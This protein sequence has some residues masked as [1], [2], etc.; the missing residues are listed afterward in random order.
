MTFH[1][2]L[3]PSNNL[4]QV[5]TESGRYYQTEDGTKLWSV[6]TL[7]DKVLGDPKKKRSLENW[8]KSVGKEKADKILIQAQ[9][10][11]TIIHET[12]EKYLLNDPKYLS[13]V[14]PVNIET[15]K[16]F[17]SVLDEHISTIYGLEHMLYSKRM[18]SAGTSDC[19]AL[20][21][22]TFSIID[23][24]NVRSKKKES[25]IQSYFYQA[26]AYALMT[27]FRHQ[28]FPEQIVILMAIDH[29]KEL[30]IFKKKTLEYVKLVYSA[31]KN[32]APKIL[33]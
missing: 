9:R 30:L 15:V 20:W 27:K 17:T 33:D 22:N 18:H 2:E 25:D 19:L 24:K 12:L 23:F 13:D 26:T 31:F 3:F 14:L 28:V 6:T 10:R 16:K 8:R 29:Q 4:K 1:H 32:K 11:G 7:L 21:D 5:N